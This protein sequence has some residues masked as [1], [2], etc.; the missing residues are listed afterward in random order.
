MKSSFPVVRKSRGF[1]SYLLVLSVAALLTLLMLSAYRRA[2]SSQE[3]SGTVQLRNDYFE[4]EDT[5]LRAILAITPN[6][7]IRAMQNDSN[8]SSETRDPLSWAAIFQDALNAGNARTSISPDV[9]SALSIT[10]H[11]R[12]NTGD[13]TLGDVAGVFGAS[14]G[15]PGSVSSGLTRS[16]GAQY[17]APL[18]SSVSSTCDRDAIYPI[19]SNDKLHGAISQSGVMLPVATYPQFNLIPYP[20]INF[21]Y[22]TPGDPFVA[23]R[24]WWSFTMDLAAHDAGLTEIGHRKR[25][26]VLSIYEI[27][28]QLA[29]SAAS[30]LSLGEFSTGEAWDPANV[31]IEGGVFASKADVVSGTN[32]P[33]IASRRGLTIG[34]NASI[35]GTE[36]TSNPFTPGIREN[37]QITEGTFFPVSLTSESGRVAFIPINRNE[38][39][40]DRYDT[41][42]ADDSNTVSNTTWNDYSIG[43]RQ[44]AMRLDVT[45]GTSPEEMPTELRFSYKRDGISVTDTIP[46]TGGPTN[47]LPPGYTYVCAENQSH[48]F[49]TALVDVA[50]GGTGRARVSTNPDVYQDDVTNYAFLQNVTGTITYDNATFGDPLVGVVKSGYYRPAYPWQIKALPSGQLCIAFYPERL[51]DYLNAINAD[52]VSVNHSIS[53]N[54]DYTPTGSIELTRPVPDVNDPN[55]NLDT[56]Y[57]VIL[58]ECA[59]LSPFT[60]GFSLVTNLRLYIGDNFNITEGT[61]P[62]GYVPEPGEPY[63]PACSI[64]SPEKRYGVE[65]DPGSVTLTGQVGSLAEENAATALSPL[66]SKTLSGDLIDSAHVR[67]NL[68]PI[69]HPADLPPVMMMNWLVVIEELRPEFAN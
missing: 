47:V 66:D 68:K 13:A 18:V 41:R 2:I 55:Y 38:V 25:E 12:A 31:S 22:A 57:G 56:H 52:D 46:L 20:Q 15:E 33:A 3:I 59:D 4:K 17:P 36:F 29:I 30:F 10:T 61:P 60:K 54:V 5:V 69:R 65:I 43:A 27:P 35:G 53:I 67:A 48:N 50:Y 26:F 9:V 19:I 11:R 39:F 32:L 58:Q 23:K 63:F 16:L 51:P 28:S 40:F 42:T 62:A 21:G 1:V 34:S 45:K 6:R 44:T 7:A 24:N 8:A 49:G 64:F 37:H 14:A